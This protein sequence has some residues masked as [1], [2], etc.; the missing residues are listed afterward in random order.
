MTSKGTGLFTFLL[1]AGIGTA[2]GIIFAPDKG[3]NTR[4]KLSYQL[5]QY[6]EK[7]LS[8]L[9]ELVSEEIQSTGSEAK[10]RSEKVVTEA[11]NKAEKLL[12]DVDK[13]IN[14]IKT[15]EPKS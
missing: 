3:I 15:K 9:D 6:R 14:Q 13:L 7:I 1:G 11:K 12:D 4:Q 2:I 8:T 5:D 10:V